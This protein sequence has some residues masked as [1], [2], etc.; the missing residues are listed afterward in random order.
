MFQY[1]QARLVHVRT[2]SKAYLPLAKQYLFLRLE[3]F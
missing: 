1:R 2:E 3:D